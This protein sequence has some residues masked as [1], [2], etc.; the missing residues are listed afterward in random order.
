MSQTNLAIADQDI[1][2]LRATIRRLENINADL[3]AA[4]KDAIALADRDLVRGNYN[5]R[6]DECGRCYRASVAAIAKAEGAS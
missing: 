2:D 1:D 3:L 5:G 4:L 6:T